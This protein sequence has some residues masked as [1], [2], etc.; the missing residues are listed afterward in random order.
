MIF[1]FCVDNIICYFL[2]YRLKKKI[3]YIIYSYIIG[4]PIRIVFGKHIG[5]IYTS[6]TGANGQTNGRQ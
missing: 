6:R 2:G 3:Q 4:S 1:M 5:Y